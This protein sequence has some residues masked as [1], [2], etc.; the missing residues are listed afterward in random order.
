M[1]PKNTS[2]RLLGLYFS[3]TAMAHGTRATE[4]QRGKHPLWV[5]SWGSEPS[6]IRGLLIP[7]KSRQRRSVAVSELGPTR[8]DQEH[9]ET[10]T[11]NKG[12]NVSNIFARK[13]M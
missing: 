4:A 12:G 10:E 9:G 8:P 5:K 11:G 1:S 6:V 3:W 2:G 7:A 13:S